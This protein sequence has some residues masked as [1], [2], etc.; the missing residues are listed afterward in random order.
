MTLLAKGE[1]SYWRDNQRQ[2]VREPWSLHRVEGGL[3]LSG[4]RLAQDRLLLQVDARWHD[5]AWRSMQ[6]DWHHGTHAERVDYV[7]HDDGLHWRRAPAVAARVLAVPPDT[8]LF[9]LLRVAAGPLLRRLLRG[10]TPVLVP[11]IRAD[12]N[13]EQR[14]QPLLS[15]R[16]ADLRSQDAQGLR[17]RYYG[18]EYG[19]TG[20]D[21]WLDAQD[22]LQR[23]RWVSTR[24]IW[25]VRLEQL[26]QQANFC[27][28]DDADTAV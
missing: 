18:G 17:C 16:R 27:G 20:A 13:D 25:E 2:P 1:Y 9:P 11:D 22:L 8:A 19:D 23:Y 26:Q 24:G 3:H 6:L 15:Q 28:F 5:G 14:L 10:E 4:Q 7:L 12:A 21:Y